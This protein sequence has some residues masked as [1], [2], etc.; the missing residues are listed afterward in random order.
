M[1]FS[2]ESL[3]TLLEL[4]KSYAPLL[5]AVFVFYVGGHISKTIAT[6][7]KAAKSKFWFRFRQTMPLHPVVLGLLFGLIFDRTNGP[8]YYAVAGVLSVF[9]FDLIKRLTGYE[10]DLPGDSIPPPEAGFT[11]KNK[12]VVTKNKSL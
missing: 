9:G 4:I 1:D 6:K 10:M 5:V 12:K 7:E 2:I 3:G 11:V 8:A